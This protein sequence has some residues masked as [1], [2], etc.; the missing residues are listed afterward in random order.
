MTEEE[1]NIIGAKGSKA[2]NSKEGNIYGKKRKE[3]GEET[4]VVK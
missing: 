2:R 1:K 4:G 3:R